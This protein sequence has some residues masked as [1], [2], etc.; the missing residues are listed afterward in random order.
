MT[1]VFRAHMGQMENLL[2]LGMDLKVL[3]ASSAKI[4][5]L[6]ELQILPVEFDFVMILSLFLRWGI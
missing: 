1:L 6:L 3:R 5:S 4:Q 2:R